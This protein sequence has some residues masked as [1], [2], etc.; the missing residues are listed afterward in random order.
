MI[1]NVL[2]GAGKTSLV[3]QMMH[4]AKPGSNKPATEVKVFQTLGIDVTDIK[5][6]KRMYMLREIGGAMQ[7]LVS[8]HGGAAASELGIFPKETKHFSRRP[9]IF[10]ERVAYS[11]RNTAFPLTGRV[12]SCTMFPDLFA[13]ARRPQWP[14]FLVDC[15]AIVFVVDS[16]NA[17]T[18]N[19]GER[20]SASN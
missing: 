10:T 4:V 14:K 16:S 17:E 15:K 19:E 5:Y 18:H 20:F 2:A 6:K 8:A 12:R 7:N 1:C 13:T 9:C 3:R 11:G